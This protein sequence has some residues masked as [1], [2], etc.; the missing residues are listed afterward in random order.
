MPHSD[1]WQYDPILEREL[2]TRRPAGG[3]I[4]AVAIAQL[5]SSEWI[6]N[7]NV[8]SRGDTWLNVCLFAQPKL[9]TYKRSEAR[10]VG[11]ERVTTCSARWPPAPAKQNHAP[12][13]PSPPP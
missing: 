2:T 7:V 4:Q 9:K 3:M 8:S 6:I 10:R 5:P 11:K 1:D 12:H 13:A